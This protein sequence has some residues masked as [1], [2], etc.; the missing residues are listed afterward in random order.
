MG[1]WANGTAPIRSFELDLP[2]AK[3]TPINDY[4][5]TYLRGRKTS[6]VSSFD[7]GVLSFW[8]ERRQERD[9]HADTRSEEGGRRLIRAAIPLKHVVS[10]QTEPLQPLRHYQWGRIPP[11]ALE[12]HPPPPPPG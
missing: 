8:S 5:I 4:L 10:G 9:N 2:L 11:A 1:E 7:I 6:L 3:A 12:G